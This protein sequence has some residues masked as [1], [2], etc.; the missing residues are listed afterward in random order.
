GIALEQP[1]TDWTRPAP[2]NPR[3]T[4]GF[5]GKFVYT[6]TTYCSVDGADNDPN[7][8]DEWDAGVRGALEDTWGWYQDA[9]DWDGYLSHF[10]I[11][12]KLLFT[13]EYFP[14]NF[15]DEDLNIPGSGNGLPDIL[16]EARWLVRFY[17]RAKDETQAKGWTTGGVPGGR[18]M[19]DL[20]GNDLGEEERGR[21]S[22]QDTNRRWILSGEDP[23]T[24]YKFVAG[25]AHLA[26][27]LQRDKLT[28]P[29]DINWVTEAETAF[30]WAE[31][32]YRSNYDCHGYDIRDARAYAAAALMRVTEKSTYDDAFRDAHRDRRR[33]PVQDGFEEREGYG[34]Y[35]YLTLAGGDAGLKANFLTAVENAADFNL[36]TPGDQRGLR[37]GGN[38]WFPMLVGQG[39]TPMV[40]EGI[41][42]YALLRERLP[43]KAARYRRVLHATADYFLGGNP[44][45]MTWITGLG[46][47]SPVRT[48]D[49]DSRYNVHD[50]PKP[51]I[52]PYGPWRDLDVFSNLGTW[53]FRWANQTLTPAIEDWP[54]H[55]RW[56]S[57]RYSP[58]TGEYTVWQNGLNA[59]VLYGV[60][61]GEADCAANP[62]SVRGRKAREELRLF[63]NPVADELRFTL[64]EGRPAVETLR[65][66][67]AAGRVVQTIQRPGPSVS[68]VELPVGI[69]FI[70][71]RGGGYAVTGQFV[72]QR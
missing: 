20:W 1:Y 54:G 45:H 49:L 9:G 72:V 3:L 31:R 58:L 35:I 23:V 61:A 55:E 32:N 14:E 56:F 44:L 6:S 34:P 29:E 67:N 57:N 13:Y 63:P 5:A 69:Y 46:E 36:L 10:D 50:F 11:P 38:M 65:I 64:P 51:G 2:H 43:M 37:W 70:E 40:W 17:K 21:G 26:Y 22:W 68:V 30:Q 39:T 27:L 4:P 59:A 33:D 12:T 66:L 48:F 53:N 24:T 15:A 28:D 47:K 7:D 16:D 62:N 25:A 42:G 8:R 18:I 19:G 71:A 41:I 60:L 52:T